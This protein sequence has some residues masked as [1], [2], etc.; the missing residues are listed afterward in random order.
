MRPARRGPNRSPHL[1][2]LSGRLRWGAGNGMAKGK[3]V[4][5]VVLAVSAALWPV[6]PSAVIASEPYVTGAPW[7][8]APSM[9]TPR[10]GGAATILRDDSVF[11]TGGL[12]CDGNGGGAC[13]DSE[14][15]SRNQGV[16][17]QTTG[18]VGSGAGMTA[19]LLRT[20][21]VL[22][23]GGAFG[24]SSAALYMPA[25]GRWLTV[26][27]VPDGVSFRTYQTATLLADG[28]VLVAGGYGCLTSQPCSEPL[29]IADIYDPNRNVWS[30]IAPM[31]SR[32]FS[33]AATL[34]PN[35]DVL[36]AGGEGCGSELICQSAEFYQPTTGRWQSAGNMSTGRDQFSATL[37]RN[38]DVLVAGGYGCLP[39]NVCRTAEIY[40][41]R[42]R[43]WTMTGS[44]N[45][46]RAGFTSTLLPTGQ[47]LVAGG[48]GCIGQTCR[49]LKSSEMYDPRTGS[50]SEAGK[51]KAAREYQSSELMRNGYVLVFGGTASCS[52][53]GCTVLSS[54]EKHRFSQGKVALRIRAGARPELN[55]PTYRC[56]TT[57]VSFTA[58][59]EHGFPRTPWI[60][61][62]PRTAPI[63]GFLFVGDRLI[64]TNG[65]MPDGSITKV[66]W[67][68]HAGGTNIVVTG[69]VR[70]TRGW[71]SSIPFGNGRLVFPRP[72]C[73]RLRIASGNVQGTATFL[74]VGD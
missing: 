66:A 39:L 8:R 34:L 16:W 60:D 23:V 70:Q 58:L 13:S 73:W 62:G 17:K 19:T 7:A 64:H 33:H 51:L 52:L 20:G 11:V 45:T 55:S 38:G 59:A 10:A 40:H 6:V 36:V 12:G 27:R 30:Q 47:V 43:R 28:R 49:H 9:S 5:A 63:R 26:G 15:Y 1:A 50:W 4:P 2:R 41:P 44:M 35:G 42:A 74:V 71:G 72:G 61:A 48:Y 54:A 25:S 29:N 67:F 22:V 53:A 69:K 57:K 24:G 68:N 37:L 18:V 31:H 46:P 3:K 21:N 14:I 32:R 56:R 65:W